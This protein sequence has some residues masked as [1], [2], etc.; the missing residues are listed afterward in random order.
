M[1]IRFLNSLVAVIESGSIAAAARKQNLTA[2]AVSQRI[3]T[4][5]NTLQCTLLIREGHSAKPSNDCLKLLPKLTQIAQL[6]S[7]LA[8]DL[9]STGLTGTLKVGVISSV[10]SGSLTTCIQRLAI[11]APDLLLQIVPGTSEQLFQQLQSQKIDL[12]VLVNPPFSL[13]K[14]LHFTPLFNEP[15]V[16]ISKHPHNILEN[17]WHSQPF[18]QYDHRS[19]GG[20]IA[21]KYL[22]DCG[23]K[24]DILCE[25]D[26]LESISL[27]AKQGMGVSL[28]PH[29]QG[30]KLMSN[31]LNIHP[32]ENPKYSRQI[33][34]LTHRQST[35]QSLIAEFSRTLSKQ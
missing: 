24:V 17:A 2:A 31:E 6:A 3:K 23:I 26:G 29:W 10:L 8:D 28:V 21:N 4:L 30:L 25:I 33:G 18:I 15:L 16:L 1:D 32:I 7:E 5:E 34:L 27:M 22:K 35:K 9:D 11:T 13:P 19:W 20:A 14:I 12:A